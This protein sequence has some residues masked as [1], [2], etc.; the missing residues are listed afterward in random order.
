MG[1]PPVWDRQHNAT[2]LKGKNTLVLQ[3]QT[4]SKITQG[5]KNPL[6][7]SFINTPSLMGWKILINN[8]DRRSGA[9]TEPGLGTS[10]TQT[11]RFRP[12]CAPHSLCRA[13]SA[14]KG[15]QLCGVQQSFACRANTAPSKQILS[16]LQVVLNVPKEAIFWGSITLSF[17]TSEA[18]DTNMSFPVPLAGTTGC[19]DAVYRATWRILQQFNSQSKNF[20]RIHV[21]WFFPSFWAFC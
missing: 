6:T 21:I 10:D 20:T 4:C 7:A 5:R 13:Q 9:R 2:Q 12:R 11:H 1:W 3:A 17:Y 16:S 15:S 8:K 19:S 14:D 18:T